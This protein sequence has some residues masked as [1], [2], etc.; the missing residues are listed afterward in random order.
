MPTFII[1]WKVKFNLEISENKVVIFFFYP[2]SQTPW[3]LS[4]H[5]FGGE[6]GSCMDPGLRM[7]VLGVAACRI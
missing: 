1:E 2:S 3:N 6:E 4:M 5:P 7:A